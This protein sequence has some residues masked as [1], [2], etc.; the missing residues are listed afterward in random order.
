MLLLGL[1]NERKERLER[2]ILIRECLG[3]RRQTFLFDISYS[4]F[5]FRAL[6]RVRSTG[7]LWSKPAYFTGYMSWVLH[8]LHHHLSVTVSGSFGYDAD[9]PLRTDP[10]FQCFSCTVFMGRW[11][12]ARTELLG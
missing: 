7:R 4:P 11:Q 5:S 3:F 9:K 10:L 8:P 12:A 1:L 2:A 6:Y